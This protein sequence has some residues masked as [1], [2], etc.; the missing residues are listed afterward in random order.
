MKCFMTYVDVMTGPEYVRFYSVKRAI[1]AFDA[2]RVALWRYGQRVS[3]TIHIA[4]DESEI[5]E[6]PDYVLETGPL[7][8]LRVQRT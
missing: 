4:D 5:A 1:Q 2:T 6:Y 7:G 3:A 8:G